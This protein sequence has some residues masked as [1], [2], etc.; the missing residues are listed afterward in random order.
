MDSSKQALRVVYR[1]LLKSARVYPSSNRQRIYDAIRQEWRENAGMAAGEHATKVEIT[2]AYKGL[3]QL[4]QFDVQQMTGGNPHASE[5]NVQ[6][7]Q[8]PMPKPDD[9]DQRKKNKRRY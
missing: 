6:L 5:W 7:E 8:N 2:R 4:G 1:Q 9:Y 3:S